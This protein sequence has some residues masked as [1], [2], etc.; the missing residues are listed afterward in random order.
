MTFQF[1]T[2]ET[3][4]RFLNRPAYLK[5]DGFP[6]GAPLP[7]Q[8]LMGAST[9]CFLMKVYLFSRLY[10]E[11]ERAADVPPRRGIDFAIPSGNGNRWEK[12]RAFSSSVVDTSFGYSF[13]RPASYDF[14]I[15][16][17]YVLFLCK[18]IFRFVYHGKIW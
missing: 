11:R 1:D 17:T 3:G 9:C 13:D 16:N 4:P 12:Q 8:P 2:L 5:G 15:L 18:H 14:E 7:E 10:R 6:D